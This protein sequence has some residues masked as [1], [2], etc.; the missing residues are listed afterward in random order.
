MP[1]VCSDGV[2]LAVNRALRFTL[3][4]L[5]VVVALVAF[6]VVPETVVAARAGE[7]AERA[8]VVRAIKEDIET[9]KAGSLAVK[10]VRVMGLVV[11]TANPRFAV[12]SVRMWDETGQ[13]VQG[14]GF[15]MQRS[16]LTGR[17]LVRHAGPSDLGCGI[18]LAVRR[19]LKL[20]CP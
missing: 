17:W 14:A 3:L 7:A 19:D 1:D 5:A 12:A 2:R 10:R 13:E 15:V 11:S 8:K 9:G 6:V 4:G 18:P 16:Y 20:S